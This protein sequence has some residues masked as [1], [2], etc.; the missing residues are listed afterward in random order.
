MYI[1]GTCPCGCEIDSDDDYIEIQDD[2]Y[3]CSWK[4]SEYYIKQNLI[5]KEIC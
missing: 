2:V 5:Y 1:I 3:L 4:C